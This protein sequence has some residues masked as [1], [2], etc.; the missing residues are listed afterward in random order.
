MPD[1]FT[2]ELNVWQTTIGYGTSPG[3]D[4]IGFES[5]LWRAL[6]RLEPLNLDVPFHRELTRDDREHRMAATATY[7]C[8]NP[9]W[10]D[11]EVLQWWDKTQAYLAD[12]A[13]WT[14]DFM[15]NTHPYDRIPRLVPPPDPPPQSTSHP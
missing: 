12:P 4:P 5:G 2:Y 11:V 9:R 15:W 7:H 3:Y 14:Y 6:N 10:T 8:F 13:L 1:V